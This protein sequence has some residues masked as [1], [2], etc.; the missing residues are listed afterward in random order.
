MAKTGFDYYNVDTDRYQDIRIKRLKKT[1]GCNGVAVYDY[2]L[3]EIYRVKG[4][5]LEW[6]E[7]T[8]FDVADYLELK[9]SAVNEI[10]NYCGV[11]GLFNKELLTSGSIISSLSIQNRYIE[12]C[13]RA[14]R[15][16]CDIPKNVIILEETKKLPEETAKTTEETQQ[17]KVEKSKEIPPPTPPLGGES[18]N[19]S[20]QNPPETN[21][22]PKEKPP[23]K[24]DFDVYKQGLREAFKSI[25]KNKEWI[26]KQEKFNPGVD[27]ILSIEKACTNY[28]ALEA[29]WKKKKG[30]QIID[31]DWPATFANAIS[32]NTNRVWKSKELSNESE[33]THV[34]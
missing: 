34:Y 26:E 28:W 27:I 21:K 25:R 6:D 13:R 8:A 12:M 3:C 31:I 1:F 7:S 23:W 11:V 20:P 18:E 32:M 10:V 9:E 24:K 29:G 22:T 4:C 15:T 30:T 19:T 5:F 16:N 2:I 33:N 17:S 14:K